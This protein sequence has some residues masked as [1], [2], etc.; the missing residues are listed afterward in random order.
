L[1]NA[2]RWEEIFWIIALMP[3]AGVAIWMFLSRHQTVASRG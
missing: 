2:Q 3:A 1:I